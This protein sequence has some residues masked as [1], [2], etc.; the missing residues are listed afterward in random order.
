[1][2]SLEKNQ[3]QSMRKIARPIIVLMAIVGI[4]SGCSSDFPTAEKSTS[5]IGQADS[6]T[7]QT[8][9]ILF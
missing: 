8:V 1:M 7:Q 6:Q 5:A 4:F 9:K 3:K 2:L